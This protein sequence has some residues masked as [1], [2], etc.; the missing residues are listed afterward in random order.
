MASRKDLIIFGAVTAGG[1]IAGYIFSKDT[2]FPRA[3]TEEVV[4]GAEADEDVPASK[5]DIVSIKVR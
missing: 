2:D 5:L 1:L 4:E 3:A